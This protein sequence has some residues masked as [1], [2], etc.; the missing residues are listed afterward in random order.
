MLKRLGDLVGL[1]TDAERRSLAKMTIADVIDAHMKW[2]LAL[3]EFVDGDCLTPFDPAT[4]GREDQSL[5]GRW[6]HQHAA[7]HLSRHGAFYTVRAMHTQFHLL[8]GEIVEKVLQGDR[9]AAA[10]MMKDRLL[11]ISYEVVQALL[12]LDRQCAEAR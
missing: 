10:V 4:A 2:K 6:I 5:A 7:E 3:Q 8:A 9:F 1:T 12:E 11:K